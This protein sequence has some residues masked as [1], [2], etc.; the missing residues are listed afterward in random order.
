MY[1]LMGMALG[2][3]SY[4]YNLPLTI[5]SALYPIFGKKIL[6]AQGIRNM[7]QH[8]QAVIELH[9]ADTEGSGDTENRILSELNVVLA[10]GLILFILFMGDT[11]F[12]L[13]ALVLNVGDYV[14]RNG[15][16]ARNTRQE[17][18][19]KRRPRHPPG[20]EE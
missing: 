19:N 5:R 16:P 1:A 8:A 15:A 14:N 17:Q 2:Y 20:P 13:N 18:A 6:C 10:L 3:F 12:L 7:E 11:E 4:R 9:H